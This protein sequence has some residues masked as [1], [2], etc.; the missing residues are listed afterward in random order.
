MLIKKFIFYQYKEIQK[1]GTISNEKLYS[2]YH[3]F[4][5]SRLTIH[6]WEDIT[7]LILFSKKIVS[8]FRVPRCGKSQLLSTLYVNLFHIIVFFYAP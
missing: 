3:G 4:I 5:V 7:K 8:K 2:A 1:T 6:F